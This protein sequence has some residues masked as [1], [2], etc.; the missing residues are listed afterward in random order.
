MRL[1][2]FGDEDGKFAFVGLQPCFAEFKMPFRTKSNKKRIVKTTLKTDERVL[3]KQFDYDKSKLGQSLI[4]ND[5]DIDFYEEGMEINHLKQVYLSDKTEIT[6]AVL[7]KEYVYNEEGELIE[8]KD[9]EKN[10]SNIQDENF[11]IRM[12]GLTV[13]IYEAM[14]RYIFNHH[15]QLI[16]INGLTYD[17]LYNIAKRLD[18]SK[19]LMYVGG[20]KNGKDPI[21]LTNGGKR[22]QAFLSGR[23]N[24]E[25]EYKLC[26]HFTNID[27]ED[28]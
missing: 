23:V 6:N 11:P 13:P 5:I 1:I 27:L 26:L 3:L 21:V 4:E 7:Y 14:R 16:H 28:Y 24:S 18:E 15:Y 8:K 20:G 19:C 22:Y 12:S 2:S 10:E 17:F 9:F 25:E